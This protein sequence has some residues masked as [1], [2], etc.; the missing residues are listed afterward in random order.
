MKFNSYINKRLS[1]S[2]GLRDFVVN[3]ANITTT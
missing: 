2:G 3:M 1:G